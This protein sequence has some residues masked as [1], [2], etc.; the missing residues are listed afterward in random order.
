LRIGVKA[1]ATQCR[2]PTYQRS[3]FVVGDAYEELG[4]EVDPKPLNP[5]VRG[6]ITL[7]VNQNI[8]THIASICPKC[9]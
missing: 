3:R 5:L 2:P 8:D 1:I 6:N 7:N 4:K 9:F